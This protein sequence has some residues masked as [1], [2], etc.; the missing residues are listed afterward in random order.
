MFKF[1]F[2]AVADTASA[3]LLP[4]EESVAVITT[5]PRKAKRASTPVAVD[6]P[7]DATPAASPAQAQSKALI[8]MTG[9]PSTAPHPF[10]DLQQIARTLITGGFVLYRGQSA[11]EDLDSS[12]VE[13]GPQ[14]S[15]AVSLLYLIGWS[16]FYHRPSMRH[17]L[18]AKN[19]IHAWVVG[20][21]V[22]LF[23]F[24]GG[25]NLLCTDSYVSPLHCVHVRSSPTN[26]DARSARGGQYQA[27]AGQYQ[28][29]GGHDWPGPGK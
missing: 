28:A 8:R 6:V 27:G 24:G 21:F 3:R 22:L 5:P 13:A 19:A 25:C 9:R 20:L 26:V 1:D 15:P 17:L 23:C 2:R 10:H 7:K 12:V 4:A 11:R 29:Q 18:F 16:E 14:Q